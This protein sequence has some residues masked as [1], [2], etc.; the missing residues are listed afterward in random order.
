MTDFV[1]K[2]YLVYCSMK[3][4]LSNVTWNPLRILHC[5]RLLVQNCFDQ[6]WQETWA[7]QVAECLALW[8][9]TTTNPCHW[10]D[11]VL[12]RFCTTVY[13]LSN[14]LVMTTVFIY[15]VPYRWSIKSGGW[16][17]F[18]SWLPPYRYS[19]RLWEWRGNW[20]STTKLD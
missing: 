6:T 1:A 3:A 16:F 2:K 9:S 19:L 8:N 18:K 12:G 20:R 15:T 4:N 11:W 13:F 5:K 17:G 7:V 14:F 10:L